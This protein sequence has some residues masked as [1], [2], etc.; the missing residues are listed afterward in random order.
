[1]TVTI[2]YIAGGA[3]SVAAYFDLGYSYLRITSAAGGAGASRSTTASSADKENE[4]IHH[5]E[6]RQSIVFVRVK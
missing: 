1:M 4:T 2:T 5:K 6:R 3:C